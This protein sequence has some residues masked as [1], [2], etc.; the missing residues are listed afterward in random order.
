MLQKTSVIDL[1]TRS[2]DGQQYDLVLVVDSGEWRTKNALH[3]LQEKIN[4]YASY[5]LDGAMVAD[6]PESK[7]R[8]KAILIQTI[9]VPP[10]DAVQFLVKVESLLKPEGLP[11]RLERLA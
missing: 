4:S 11:V 8:K 5:A 3:A 10:E 1:V 9:D 6:Y 7:G 2:K